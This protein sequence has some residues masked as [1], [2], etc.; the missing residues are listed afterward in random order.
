MSN[1]KTIRD[2]IDKLK[3]TT[4]KFI[5]KSKYGNSKISLD[6]HPLKVKI[7]GN[8]FMLPVEKTHELYGTTYSMGVEFAEEDMDVFDKLIV[9]MFSRI[10]DTDFEI[11]VPHNGGT[12]FFKLKT[13]ESGENFEHESN[14]VISP[15][16]L[17]HEN[18]E[19]NIDVTVELLISGWYMK[20]GGTKKLG[21]NLKVQKIWFGG[22][23]TK[24]KKRKIEDDDIEIL[25]P[26]VMPDEKKKVNFM[27]KVD[28]KIIEGLA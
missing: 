16:Q 23:K 13:N 9:M 21:L 24:G 7:T 2:K 11:K 3:M 1:L 26:T 22:E 6:G 15:D 4:P 17:N 27:T 10:G 20:S 8:L 5:G 12:I 28:R 19:R 14:V 18:I 25:S